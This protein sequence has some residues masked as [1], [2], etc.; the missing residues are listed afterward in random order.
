VIIAAISAALLGLAQAAAQPP[1]SSIRQYPVGGPRQLDEL[2]AG[3]FR[4]QLEALPPQAQ[5]RALAWLRSFHFTEQD[6]PSL[7]ADPGGGI[8]YACALQLAD[9]TPEPDEPP[10]LGEPRCR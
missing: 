10:P 7:H 8:L 1:P 2:P 4:S 6:L 9:P 5:E 3:R